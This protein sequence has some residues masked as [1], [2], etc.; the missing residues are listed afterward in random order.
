M[1]LR[2]LAR[3]SAL[4]GIVL[5]AST[6]RADVRPI[7]DAERA[8]VQIAASYLS[9]GPEAVAEQLASSSPL[10]KLPPQ[11]ALA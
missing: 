5:L 8:A 1:R 4:C 10:K 6:L 9:R 7:S 11:A 3:G 2:Q